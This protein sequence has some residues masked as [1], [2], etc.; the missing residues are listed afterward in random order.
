MDLTSL[1]NTAWSGRAEL[2]LDPLG[3]VASTS[4]AT[5]QVAAGAVQYGWSHE[6]TAHKGRLAW[7]QEGASFVD[8]FHSAEAMCCRFVPEAWGMLQVQGSYSGGGQDWG[9]RI[10]L[11]Y[12]APLEQLVLLMTNIAP[13]GEEVRAF[14]VTCAR[15]AAA[16][17]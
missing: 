7:D 3:D 14:R 15:D 1:S 5:I 6:G 12:R 2:W 13:W 4:P 8:T 17:T 10:G 16:A 11:F 9:W